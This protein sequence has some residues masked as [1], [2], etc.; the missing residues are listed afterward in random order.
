MTE[1]RTFENLDV[2]K[3]GRDL[4]KKFS[5]FSKTLPDEEKYLLRSQI[6]RASRSVTANIAEGY[7]RFH[8][9]ENIQFCKQS[10]G[11]LMELLDHISVALDEDY[12][13]EE[14]YQD[15]RSEILHLTKVLNGYIAFL[16]KSKN[17]PK[18][19]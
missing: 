4:R 6:L 19:D 18:N 14:M 8:Y 9:K 17:E 12:L 11:S 3:L 7:G 2:W 15:F 16:S 1:S 10:R 13:S 5:V